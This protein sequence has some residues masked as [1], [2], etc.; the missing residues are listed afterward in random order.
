MEVEAY[1]WL[2]IIARV[3]LNCVIVLVLFLFSS[4]G[5]MS[6]FIWF[7]SFVLHHLSSFYNVLL[8]LSD[9]LC[10]SVPLLLKIFFDAVTFSL[11]LLLM[12]TL[13]VANTLTCLCRWEPASGEE[14]PGGTEEIFW[15]CT[16]QTVSIF[17]VFTVFINCFRCIEL[18]CWMFQMTSRYIVNSP[19]GAGLI[20]SVCLLWF[21]P[22]LVLYNT[23]CLV[24]TPK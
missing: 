11:Y 23:V 24:F 10:A 18:C 3:F 15:I 20:G 16:V 21:I 1:Y 12:S 22:L 6:V 5:F 8:T 4:R 17:V 14:I 9:L 7:L 19:K 13:F 2:H